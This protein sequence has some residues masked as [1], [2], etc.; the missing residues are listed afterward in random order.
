MCSEIAT[1]LEFVSSALYVLSADVSAIIPAHIHSSDSLTASF[2]YIYKIKGTI[3]YFLT[4]FWILLQMKA[5]PAD[6]PEACM[7]SESRLHVLK[8]PSLPMHPP[9]NVTMPLPS[10]LAVV[11]WCRIV[12][13]SRHR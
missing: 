12:T 8:T 5:S 10:T 13:P 9:P 4:I 1:P 2:N 3:Y 7:S 11:S 6:M